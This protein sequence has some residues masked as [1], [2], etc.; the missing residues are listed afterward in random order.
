MHEAPVHRI[1]GKAFWL[2]CVFSVRCG[3]RTTTNITPNN[4][5]ASTTPGS[6]TFTRLP[7]PIPLPR[8][9]SAT[10]KNRNQIFS[11][12]TRQLSKKLKNTA[13]LVYVDAPHLLTKDELP[14]PLPSLSSSPLE[15]AATKAAAAAA[16]AAAK[17][18]NTGEG[19]ALG[20]A[21]GAGAAAEEEG[22]ASPQLLGSPLP[23]PP[24]SPAVSSCGRKTPANEEEEEGGVVVKGASRAGSG[25][26]SGSPPQ[27]RAG[28]R[29]WWR[30]DA[31]ERKR[32]KAVPGM[33]GRC[34]WKVRGAVVTW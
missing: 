11:Q 32:A 1:S 14:P 19:G 26:G 27:D 13:E 8:P 20:L 10:T 31:E 28:A 9:C 3:Q 4:T 5:N 7:S 22:L 16:A 33:A 30:C 2:L 21:V 12:R 23:T 24:P 25:S 6:L 34:E 18:V 15:A 29:T 17:V